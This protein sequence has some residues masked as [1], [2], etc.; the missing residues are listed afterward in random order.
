VGLGGPEGQ[1]AEPCTNALVHGVGARL[2]LLTFRPSFSDLPSFSGLGREDREGCSSFLSALMVPIR[3]GRPIEPNHHR[4]GGTPLNPT[5]QPLYDRLLNGQLE[6]GDSAD[7]VGALVLHC[8][9]YWKVHA[10]GI[11]MEAANGA[12]A[13]LG[14]E[15]RTWEL[16][17][18]VRQALSNRP[19][20]KRSQGFVAAVVEVAGDEAL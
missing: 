15:G 14:F 1:E 17:E 4:A 6:R 3:L 12:R 13:W 19:S 11:D 16:G 5:A 10:R 2:S 18:G 7:A 9:E 20:L 8:V